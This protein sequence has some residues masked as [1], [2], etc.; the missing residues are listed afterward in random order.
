MESS[1]LI[2]SAH[3]GDRLKTLEALR[4]LL[5]RQISECDS[6]R[7]TAALSNQL[8]ATLTEIDQLAPKVD[9]G[10]PVD[11]IAQRRAARRASTAKGANRAKRTS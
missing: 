4:D 8:R 9:V 11:E 1:G 3:S 7:D 10:D 5:A 2:E 6:M